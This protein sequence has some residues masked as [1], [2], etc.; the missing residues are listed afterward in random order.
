MAGGNSKSG[1]YKYR[2]VADALRQRILEG[3]LRPGSLVPSESELMSRYGVGRVTARAA[4]RV[5]ND[6]G[7]ISVRQGARSIVLGAG[8]SGRNA[9]RVF[10]LTY[11]G[12]VPL[13]HQYNIRVLQ[14][15]HSVLREYSHELEMIDASIEDG[16]SF[17]GPNR[18]KFRRCDGVF[19]MAPEP[20]DANIYSLHEAGKS[21]VTLGIPLEHKGLPIYEVPLDGTRAMRSLVGHLI[22]LGHRKLG[23]VLVASYEART[24]RWVNQLTLNVLNE[25]VRESGV[26]VEEGWIRKASEFSREAGYQAGM[27]LLSGQGP[28]PTAIIAVGD[29]LALG[30]CQAAR[31]VGLAVPGR[32]SVTGVGNYFPEAELTTLAVPAFNV[33]V[34]AAKTMLSAC[35]GKEISPPAPMR[36]PLVAGKTTTFAPAEAIEEL[37]EAAIQS[38]GSGSLSPPGRFS[39]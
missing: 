11:H 20:D 23:V 13:F 24:R 14:G 31:E 2:A 16:S 17:R 32:L 33:G 5:L 37:H 8:G 1:D 4:V 34:R 6:E 36:I 15:I 7:L 10:G 22:D 39:R 26:K 38:A 25:A 9:T 19:L 18:H 27:Q 30:V 28:K 3:Q 21:L 29:T 12:V 35:E